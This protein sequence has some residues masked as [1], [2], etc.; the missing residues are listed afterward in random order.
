MQL[1]C[2]I[3]HNSLAMTVRKPHTTHKYVIFQLLR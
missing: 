3:V 2:K 1:I